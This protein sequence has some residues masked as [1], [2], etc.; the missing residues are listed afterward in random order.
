MSG[1]FGVVHQKNCAELLFYGTD[2]HSHLGTEFGGLATWRTDN[3]PQIKI[4]DIRNS[5]FKSKFSDD[6]QKMEGRYGIGIISSKYPQP[7]SYLSKSGLFAICVD[8][9]IQNKDVLKSELINEHKSLSEL[10]IHSINTAEL[11]AKLITEKNTFIEGIENAFK[12]IKGSI[13]LLLLTDEGIYAARDKFG[14]TPLVVGKSERGWAV[15]SETASFTNLGFQIHKYLGP[16]E[17]V[18]VN[19]KGLTQKKKAGNINKICAFYW[20]YTGFPAS[21]YEGI[22]VE[23]VREKCGKFLARNDTIEA[24]LTSGVPDSGIAH[25]VGYAM[26]SGM[27]LR[28]P[29]LKYTPG[30]G[31]SYT[32]PSQEIR[33]RI[34][35]MK[36]IPNKDIIKNNRIV[37]CEDSIVR[38]TQ[39]KNFTIQKLWES[40]AKEVHIR[41][42]C[43]P[44]MYPCKYNFS[45]RTI[46][47]LAARKA[48]R[49]IEGEDITEIAT[50]IDHNSEKYKEMVEWIKDDL[51]ATS[52]QYQRLQDMVKAIGLKKENL[53]LYCWTGQG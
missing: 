49:A 50:Y 32:P 40:G 19:D 34:A 21:Y 6:Y 38:G 12:K 17:I 3:W 42:A 46:H 41:V 44:L 20:I 16:G 18:L 10:S 36:L 7:M 47:E 52:L 14:R 31:R 4:H 45:T 43:P 13:S 33:D 2:Y 27:P 22:N 39:L 5:Q 24:D 11:V 26:E 28:R 8:G 35:L 51:K 37:L 25:A 48:I 9:L 29:L 1:L 23:N 15:A 53:C 30:Y